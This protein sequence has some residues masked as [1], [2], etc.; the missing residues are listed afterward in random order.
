MDM[1][2]RVQLLAMSPH[3]M[4]PPSPTTV[5]PLTEEE[6]QQFVMERKRL[7]RKKRASVCVFC[8][9]NGEIEA[10]YIS[11]TLKVNKLDLI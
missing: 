11:H 6:L 8:K 1:V 7:N 3:H 10:V 2:T 5:K 4:R 9:N